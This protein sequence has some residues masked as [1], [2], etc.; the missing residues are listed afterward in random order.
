MASERLL[1]LQRQCQDLKNLHDDAVAVR[2]EKAKEAEDLRKQAEM[3]QRDAEAHRTEK[4]N[5]RSQIE[6]LTRNLQMIQAS[7]RDRDVSLQRAE[8]S[9][10]QLAQESPAWVQLSLDQLV[11]AVIGE[12]RDA[13]RGTSHWKTVADQAKEREAELRREATDAKQ[14]ASEANHQAAE[15]A[16]EAEAAKREISIEKT[17]TEKAKQENA[18][19]MRRLRTAV[20]KAKENRQNYV[21]VAHQCKALMTKLKAAQPLAQK[22]KATQAQLKNTQAL[23]L[24]LKAALKSALAAVEKG[25]GMQATVDAERKRADSFEKQLQESKDMQA[26]HQQEVDRL[27]ETIDKSRADMAKEKSKYAETLAAA[28]SRASA[29]ETR[30]S[31]AETRALEAEEKVTNAEEKAS[32]AEEKASKALEE[33][34]RVKTAE[35]SGIADLKTQISTLEEAKKA[36]EDSESSLKQKLESAEKDAGETKEALTKAEK[37]VEEL[38]TQLDG[39]RKEKSELETELQEQTETAEDYDE[40]NTIL[41]GENDQLQQDLEAAKT[42]LKAEKEAR[43][44]EVAELK[45]SIANLEELEQKRKEEDEAAKG[46]ALVDSDTFTASFDTSEQQALQE[47][48]DE[49]VRKLDEHKKQAAARLAEVTEAKAESDDA[50]SS[51]QG[52][53]RQLEDDKASLERELAGLKARLEALKEDKDN[54]HG[55]KVSELW[56]QVAEAKKASEQS[57]HEQKAIAAELEAVKHSRDAHAQTIEELRSSLAEKDQERVDAEE[58]HRSKLTS[59]AE[60]H[61]AAVFKVKA[62]LEAEHRKVQTLE[63]A[64]K[65]AAAAAASAAPPT[66]GASEKDDGMVKMLKG[67]L[68]TVSEKARKYKEVATQ[69]QARLRKALHTL[70]VQ[71]QQVFDSNSSTTGNNNDVSAEIAGSRGRSVSPSGRSSRRSKRPAQDSSSTSDPVVAELKRRSSLMRLQLDKAAQERKALESQIQSLSRD[72]ASMALK[73]DRSTLTH[74]GMVHTLT[75]DEERQRRVKLFKSL[76]NASSIEGKKAE[77]GTIRPPPKVRSQTS[78]MMAMMEGGGDEGSESEPLNEEPPNLPVPS[79]EGAGANSSSSNNEMVSAELD[80]LQS[81]IG[82]L[83]AEL[84]IKQNEWEEAKERLQERLDA[85]EKEEKT[86]R[87]KAERALADKNK[88]DEALREAEAKAVSAQ[89]EKTKAIESLEKAK[90]GAEEKSNALVERAS[91]AEKEAADVQ[92]KLQEAVAARKEAEAAALAAEESA[93]ESRSS[94]ARSEHVA[95]AYERLHSLLRSWEG[96]D[97]KERERRRKIDEERE[98]KEKEKKDAEEKKEAEEQKRRESSLSYRLFGKKKV[99]QMHMKQRKS[100]FDES[101]GTYV[102]EGGDDDDDT[103]KKKDGG[104]FPHPPYMASKLPTWQQLQAS[105]P[106]TGTPGKRTTKSLTPAGSTKSAG[107]EKSSPSAGSTSAPPRPGGLAKPKS[108]RVRSVGSRYGS[109]GVSGFGGPG[110]RGGSRGAPR[111][112]MPRARLPAPAM[113]GRQGGASSGSAPARKPMVPMMPK[114]KSSAPPSAEDKPP[115]SPDQQQRPQ[116]EKENK[117]DAAA[118]P[119]P[120]PKKPLRP[121]KQMLPN[122]QLPRPRASAPGL[123]AA[124]R[125]PMAGRALRPLGRPMM[126]NKKLASA[127]GGGPSTPQRFGRP[128]PAAAASPPAP[129]DTTPKNITPGKP[130]PS[131]LAAS[132]IVPP[133]PRALFPEGPSHGEAGALVVAKVPLD[134]SSLEKVLGMKIYLGAAQQPLQPEAGG[135]DSAALGELRSRITEL[136]VLLADKE[137]EIKNNTTNF[138]EDDGDKEDRKAELTRA[139]RRARIAEA[140]L[141]NRDREMAAQSHRRITP[142]L[143]SG[144]RIIHHDGKLMT[145]SFTLSKFSVAAFASMFAGVYAAGTLGGDAMFI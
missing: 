12:L 124:A 121:K 10:N 74:T 82:R 122:K 15:A 105:S 51:V 78:V 92:A 114:P 27:K 72:K 2:D 56:G 52:Q 40:K 81:K 28:E 134:I 137:N 33:I 89:K 14:Q 120:Q 117:E 73:L 45:Q 113:P 108:S 130:V 26:R 85:S 17:A 38:R 65:K 136:E 83:E 24:K 48:R 145:V 129:A 123:G 62:L 103:Q 43:E 4:E 71:Q 112:G 94:V 8:A 67:K 141:V 133:K 104:G 6:T 31:E 93:A 35:K 91:A 37:D 77:K 30:V 135:G 119:A 126:G 44:K 98:K 61:K 140:R 128:T 49:A 19:L 60:E 34:Q 101:T 16:R 99:K 54:D 42:T 115:A 95:K 1:V 58:A 111:P 110:P 41:S 79:S 66:G 23:S 88:A 29:A 116:N 57:Q 22:L 9:R 87:D 11:P 18:E 139:L 63:A 25:K 13:K 80:R 143:S 96:Y 20:E 125:K 36:A 106:S 64:N 97:K 107:A 46:N 69:L 32:E 132:P 50:L 21:K 39:V 131:A 142:S 53:L 102:F 47:A 59:Q 68:A 127:A 100:W 7:V 138:E 90:Q 144:A 5:F 86:A 75:R 118:A 109:L 55:G 70:K 3:H 84:A 76:S